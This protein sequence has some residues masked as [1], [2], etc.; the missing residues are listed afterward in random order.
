VS[1]EDESLEAI[2]Y[3]GIRDWEPNAQKIA[4]GV[5]SV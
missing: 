1:A 3:V 2:P 5:R 4:A